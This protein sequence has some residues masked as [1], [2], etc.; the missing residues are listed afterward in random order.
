M[1]TL[2]KSERLSSRKQIARLFEE[3][4]GFVCF[5]Y[6]VRWVAAGEEPSSE[7][8]PV[9]VLVTVTKRR[10]KHAVDRNRV[11][12]VTR[13]CYRLH[14][15]NLY[16]RLAETGA[17]PLLLSLS[18]IDSQLPDFHQAMKRFDT[19]VERLIKELSHETGAEDHN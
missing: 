16:Q 7:V 4:Q 11:K 17:E 12:R 14:K 13:E 10:F 19:I 2:S 3:G 15:V 8:P 18:Y 5:P 6:S 9:R 1:N